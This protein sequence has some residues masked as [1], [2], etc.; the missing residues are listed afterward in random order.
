MFWFASR[1]REQKLSS[2]VA[3]WPRLVPLIGIATPIIRNG[4]CRTLT[5]RNSPF[6]CGHLRAIP[7]ML[8]VNGTRMSRKLLMSD[9][10]REALFYGVI[11]LLVVARHLQIIISK[12]F[13]FLMRHMPV[14]YVCYQQDSHCGRTFEL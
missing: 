10:S 8:S 2:F 11:A 6:Q 12:N 14:S 7:N 13:I 5:Q 9:Y 3:N 4:T 1:R